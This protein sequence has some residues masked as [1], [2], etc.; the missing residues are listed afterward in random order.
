MKIKNQLIKLLVITLF[1]FALI[2]C[3]SKVDD[4]NRDLAMARLGFNNDITTVFD[5][6]YF[7]AGAGMLKQQYGINQAL[8]DKVLVPKGYVKH[9]QK[10]VTETM[11]FGIKNTYDANWYV[12]QPKLKQI[13]TEGVGGFWVRIATRKFIQITSEKEYEQ[14]GTKFLD[15]TFS[16]N[17]IPIIGGLPQLG[18]FEGKATLVWNL[19]NKNWDYSSGQLGDVGINEFASKF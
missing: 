18:P 6:I 17:I 1:V 5:M 10:K 9:I 13:G 12:P 14:F 8:I 3:G 4:K 15:F 11:I 16:Y 2:S 19:S 7:G